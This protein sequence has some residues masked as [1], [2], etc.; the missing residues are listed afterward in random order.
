MGA[1]MNEP[2]WMRPGT[3]TQEAGHAGRPV[4]LALGYV[5]E[6]LRGQQAAWVPG[7]RQVIRRADLACDLL[8]SPPQGRPHRDVDAQ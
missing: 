7:A 2:G 3:R 5:F 4:A 6:G 8:P 1:G